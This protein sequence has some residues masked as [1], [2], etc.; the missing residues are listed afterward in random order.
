MSNSP[1]KPVVFLSSDEFGVER[2]FPIRNLVGDVTTHFEQQR[3][4]KE[5]RGHIEE[6]VAPGSP[7]S[8]FP[9]TSPQGAEDITSDP[10]PIAPVQPSSPQSHQ[11]QIPLKDADRSLPLQQTDSQ[12]S[13]QTRSDGEEFRRISRR[14]QLVPTSSGPPAVTPSTSAVEGEATISRC[15]DEPI[16]IPGAI[17]AFGA[18]VAVKYNAVGNLRVRIASENTSKFLTYSPEDLFELESFLDV[19]DDGSKEDIVVRVDYA[20]ET[21]KDVS[22]ETLLDVLQLTIRSPD[23]RKVPLWCAIHVAQGSKDLLILE[24]ETFSDDLY[25]GGLREKNIDP[26]EPTHTLDDEV[27]PEEW[28]K[29]TTS[30]SEPLRVLEIS[31]RKKNKSF[32]SI[33]FFNVMTEAQQQ[34]ANSANVQILLDKLVGLISEISGFHRV[35]FYRFDSEKNGCVDAELVNHHASRDIFRGKAGPWVESCADTCRFALSSF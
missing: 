12:I 19:L 23:G 17:Q 27:V 2:V 22:R 16:H 13:G 10:V 4:R 18:L 8:S 15:E 9:S 20:L 35:M 3:A 6:L 31:R 28:I 25:H 21:V 14:V 32:S 26:K 7:T 5:S 34:L 24:F 30:G 1:P 33:E 29:S 11:S